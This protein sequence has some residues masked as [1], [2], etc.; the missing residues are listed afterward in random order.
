MLAKV[1]AS[2]DKEVLTKRLADNNA[3][4][5]AIAS[6]ERGRPKLDDAGNYTPVESPKGKGKTKKK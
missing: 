2:P 4:L 5:P 3:A 6:D 1:P